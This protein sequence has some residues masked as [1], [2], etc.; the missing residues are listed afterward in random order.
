MRSVRDDRRGACER[1][2]GDNWFYRVNFAFKV[3]GDN[4][5]LISMQQMAVT[6]LS[7]TIHTNKVSKENVCLH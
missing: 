6:M 7:F 5:V 2:G 4:G 3:M 1:G